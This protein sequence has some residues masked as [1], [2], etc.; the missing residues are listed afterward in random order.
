MKKMKP[1]ILLTIAYISRL[2]V[3]PIHKTIRKSSTPEK[4]VFGTF[5]NTF[6]LFK[7]AESLNLQ[8][9]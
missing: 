7:A 1:N 9:F 2:F 8:S 6:E 4:Q 5:K 3:N